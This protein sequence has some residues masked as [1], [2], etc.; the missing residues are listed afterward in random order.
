MTKPSRTGHPNGEHQEVEAVKPK[1]R[2]G[3]L[4]V[5]DEVNESDETRN[6]DHEI[7]EGGHRFTYFQRTQKHGRI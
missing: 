5:A 7:G 2:F 3:R 1:R 6:R 4:L